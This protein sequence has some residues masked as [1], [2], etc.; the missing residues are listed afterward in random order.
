MWPFKSRQPPPEPAPASP[1]P[2]YT[3][4]GSV[5]VDEMYKTFTYEGFEIHPQSGDSKIKNVCINCG[6]D[7]KFDNYTPWSE[8]VSKTWTCAECV[9]LKGK[10]QKDLDST[11]AE[12]EKLEGLREKLL[13]ALKQFLG[14]EPESFKSVDLKAA[15]LILHR[16]SSTDVVGFVLIDYSREQMHELVTAVNGQLDAFSRGFKLL[17][18]LNYYLLFPGS[19]NYDRLSGYGTRIG[20]FYDSYAKGSHLDSLIEHRS[21]IESQAEAIRA[22][23]AAKHAAQAAKA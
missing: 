22:R 5:P 21:H 3:L 20:K 17:L 23:I 14:K 19:S 16:K 10:F 7:V 9:W 11:T 12:I 8:I 18:P 2:N 15:G 4:F 6:G 13:N 1:P